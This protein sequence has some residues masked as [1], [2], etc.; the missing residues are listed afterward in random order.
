MEMGIEADGEDRLAATIVPDDTYPGMYR[1]KYANGALS[2]M[3]NLARAKDALAGVGVAAA[4]QIE[5]R[6]RDRGRLQELLTALDASE[7]QLR[8]DECGDWRIGGTKGHIY[9]MGDAFHLV[10]FTD[11]C[12]FDHRPRSSRRW[13][14]AKQRLDFARVIQDGD[15][16][17]I[18]RLANLP[19]ELEALEIREVLGIRKRR[20]LSPEERERAASR[21]RAFRNLGDAEGEA[22]I[23]EVSDFDPELMAFGE[24]G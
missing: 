15:E 6:R 18:L 3:V 17:G 19:S 22:N 5:Q 13:T 2:G 20:H 1:L 11:E 23:L 16:E 21:L 12:D 24:A 10:A 4:E 7:R 8:R 9:A 14:F